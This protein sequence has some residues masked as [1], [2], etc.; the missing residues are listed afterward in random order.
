MLLKGRSEEVAAKVIEAFK[1]GNLAAPLATAYLIRTDDTPIASWSVLNQFVCL[2]MGCTDPRGYDQWQAV[3]R[4]VVKGSTARAHILIPIRPYTKK[5][6]RQ[7]DDDTRRG[8]PPIGFTTCP[9]FD[10]TQTEGDPIPQAHPH[11]H[12]LDALPLVT[13]AQAWSIHLDTY[14][15]Q[16]GKAQGY[17]APRANAIRLGVENIGVWLHELTHAADYR[18]G[19]L[20]ETGQHW[21]SETV[22]E[23]GACVLAH[24]IGQ[25]E[26][27]D[28]GQT[29]RYITRYAE[30][31]KIE[32][33]TACSRVLDRTLQA[34]DL[35]ISTAEAVTP[36]M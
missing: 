35:I 20:T 19:N 16:K 32:P 31:A 29:Y 11:R 4:H 14:T 17:F 12:F 7:T 18:L 9:V 34:V 10:I 30:A 6:D 26:H 24:M 28:E 2:L 3:G 25:P 23:L 1:T 21:R 8:G 15:G 22:A 13:V 36:V 27:A 33:I 5:A